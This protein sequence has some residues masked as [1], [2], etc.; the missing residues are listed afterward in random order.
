MAPKLT[1]RLFA[2]DLGHRLGPWEPFA[3]LDI[4]ICRHCG[5]ESEVRGEKVGGEATREKCEGAI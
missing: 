1:A 3:G 2:A 5:M 4:S